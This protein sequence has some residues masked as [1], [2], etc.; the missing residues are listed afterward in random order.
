MSYQIEYSAHWSNDYECKNGLPADLVRATIKDHTGM[1]V[2]VVQ[3]K[4]FFN[5][6]GAA[7]EELARLNQLS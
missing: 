5:T 4:E 2:F 7:E 3:S 1:T 6:M